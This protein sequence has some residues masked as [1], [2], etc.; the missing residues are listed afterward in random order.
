MN[1]RNPLE[2]NDWDFT[3][4]F[5]LTVSL[6]ALVWV[7]LGLDI[8]GLHVP[9]L[10]EL[11]T[12][13][14]LLFVPGIIL[15]RVLRVHERNHIECLLYS[16]GLSVATVMITG[17]FMNTLYLR[18]IPRPISLLPF[19]VTMTA[20]VTIL[21]VLSYYRDREFSHPK[22]T[23]VSLGLS[24][25]P[26]ALCLLP[27]VSIFGAYVFNFSGTSIGTVVTLLGVAALIVICGFTSWVPRRYFGLAT[28]VAAVALLLHNSLITNYVWGNDIQG[29]YAVAQFVVSNG[30]WGAPPP[31]IVLSLNSMLSLTTLAPLLSIATGMSL[32]WV[33]KLIVPLL[34]ALVPLGLF[35]LYQKQT[36][37]RT[38][39]FGSF[40][41]MVTFSFYTEMLAMARQEIAELFVVMLLLLI[42]DRQM[43][44]AQRFVLFGLF[45]FSL[46]V[47]HYALTYVFFFCF[48]LALLVVSFANRYDLGVLAQR[49]RRNSNEQRTH[50]FRR[51]N[52]QARNVGINALL[53][54]GLAFLALLWYRFANNP[55]P[56]DNFISIVTHIATAF[57]RTPIV[58]PSVA[59]SGANNI[60]GT[61]TNSPSGATGSTVTGL[62]QLLA[63]QPPIHEVTLYLTLIAV[64]I[65][66]IG[67]LFAYRE[68]QKFSFAS[69]YVALAGAS[70]L[71]LLF[72]LVVPYFAAN[73]QLSRFF[74]ISQ[75][76]LSVFFVIGFAGIVNVLKPQRD[77]S[78]GKGTRELSFKALALFVVILFVFHSGLAYKATGELTDSPT[79]LGFNKAVNIAKF[80]DQEMVAARWLNGN[81]TGAPSYADIFRQFA[82]ISVNRPDVRGFDV[83]SG[84]WWMLPS[85]SYLYL[86][87]PNVDSGTLS[88]SQNSVTMAITEVN[89]TYFTAGADHIY[90]NGGAQVFV[91]P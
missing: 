36:S 3:S 16:V 87:T 11:F 81:A 88:I 51:T 49:L 12:L 24:P 68:R 6:Q 53:V 35:R 77:A 19:I 47:S 66:V 15:L 83:V 42:V 39:L 22:A 67:I 78:T 59:P 73:L 63:Y 29:E 50:S 41:F 37:H 82:L 43:N 74:H 4:F 33:F 90:S 57:G 60:L 27:F 5:A 8:I 72:C 13:I 46:I 31:N 2:A 84:L 25:V 62:Q 44:R 30:F 45:G 40:Y 56:I 9:I 26:V 14:Y 10:R 79:V 21:L 85:G 64:I 70:V 89:S 54:A 58:Q 34:F 55:E 61:L 52:P 38:A 32:T 20:L 71:L 1:I 86:G 69:E 80:S 18:F 91:V 17:L 65:S 23:D 76:F 7:L 28:L 48:V 75:I